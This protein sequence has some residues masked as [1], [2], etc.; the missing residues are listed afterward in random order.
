VHHQTTQPTIEE[1]TT[2][3]IY[4]FTFDNG[5]SEEVRGNEINFENGT[6]SVYNEDEN[7]S[8]IT[9]ENK[10]L[11][12]KITQNSEDSERTLLTENK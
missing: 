2:V 8:Y 12:V 10:V 3:N 7:L 1:K 5:T 9:Y 4:V 6:I 11:S